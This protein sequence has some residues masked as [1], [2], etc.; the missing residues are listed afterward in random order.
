V[1]GGQ[2]FRIAFR[3]SGAVVRSF[4]PAAVLAVVVLSVWAVP[5]GRAGEWRRRAGQGAYAAQRNRLIR[6]IRT[7]VDSARKVLDTAQSKTKMSEA[8]LKSAR[9]RLDEAKREYSRIRIRLLE[10]SPDWVAAAKTAQEALQKESRARKDAASAAGPSRA[11][12]RELRTQKDLAAQ[13]QAVVAQ[14][15]A[16]LRRLG[17]KDVGAKGKG[18]SSS[19]KEK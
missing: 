3:P 7:Q 5:Q 4:L 19:G 2:V 13:A 15:E 1:H 9:E 6:E 14:G 8:D 10:S 18:T 16:A 11:A 12:S 17:V